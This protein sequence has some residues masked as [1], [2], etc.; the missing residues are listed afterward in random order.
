MPFLRAYWESEKKAR[1]ESDVYVTSRVPWILSDWRDP[2]PV[3]IQ[4]LGIQDCFDLSRHVSA[5]Y[6]MVGQKLADAMDRSRLHWCHCLFVV[7]GAWCWITVLCLVHWVNTY[8]T[9]LFAYPRL[10]Q[11]Y[12]QSHVMSLLLM[13]YPG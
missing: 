6:A 12:I 11:T 10:S 1:R 8:R 9:L 2:G 7:V 4:Y 5:V 3:R 13:G